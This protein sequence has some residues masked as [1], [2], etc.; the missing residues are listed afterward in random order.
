MTAQPMNPQTLASEIDALQG[1]VIT[2]INNAESDINNYIA[3]RF[4]GLR[5]DVQ[6][7]FNAFRTNF[8]LAVQRLAQGRQTVA[9]AAVGVRVCNYDPS[10]ANQVLGLSRR[11]DYI[12]QRLQLAVP[13]VQQAVNTNDV[14]AINALADQAGQFAAMPTPVGVQQAAAIG[15]SQAP[16]PPQQFATNP[17]FN[18]PAQPV[19]QYPGHGQSLYTGQQ[20]VPA[21]PAHLPIAM[22]INPYQG[23]GQQPFP[24][25]RVGRG[26]AGFSRILMSAFAGAIILMILG[27]LIGVLVP[28]HDAMLAF[29][30]WGA[31]L[32]FVG[33][34]LIGALSN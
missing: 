20:I 9:Q 24:V 33:G 17:Y 27:I 14:N 10:L 19:V 31:L 6:S 32:G 18:T 5:G 29:A 11:L 30:E 4:N 12:D 25:P 16:V 15:A 13:G 2:G 22:P 26:G 1:V 23:Y 3:Q 28:P 34:G 7:A 8:G 21:P